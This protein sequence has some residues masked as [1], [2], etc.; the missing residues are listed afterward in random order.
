MT[1]ASNIEKTFISS[2]TDHSVQTAL[3]RYTSHLRAGTPVLADIRMLRRD[4][5]LFQ[6]DGQLTSETLEYQGA[7]LMAFK[8]LYCF[9]WQY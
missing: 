8:A 6:D 7:F 9:Q 2:V 4:K 1:L 5:E 3:P